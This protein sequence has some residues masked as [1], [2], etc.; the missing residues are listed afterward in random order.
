MALERAGVQL[1]ADGAGPFFAT[2][3]RGDA[4][5]ASFARATTLASGGAQAFARATQQLRLDGLTNQL[6]DQTARLELL[7][8]Q[9][10][11]TAAKYGESSTQAQ[12]KAVAV[13]KLGAQIGITERKIAL[14]TAQMQSESGAAQRTAAS[15]GQIEDGA[16]KAGGAIDQVLIGALRKVGAVGVDMLGKA[17]AMFGRFV[18]DGISG[19]ADY[20][21]NLSLLQSTT[22]A[23]DDQMARA[24]A[25]AKALGADLTLPATSAGSAASAMTAL[26]QAGI[27]MDDAIAGAKGTLQLAAAG[28][29]ADAEAAEYI[30]AALNQF[31]LAGSQAT[32]VADLMAASISAAGSKVGQTGQAIQQA[33]ASFAAAKIPV[34]VLVTAIDLMAKAGIK[35]SDAGTAL[36]TML[37]RLQKPTDEAAALMAHMGI[38]IYDAEGAMRPMRD[39]I[40]QFSTA[41]GGMTQEQRA[42]AVVT[43]FGTDAQRAANIV[44][45]GG[46]AAYDR[47][48]AAVTRQNAA[49]DQAAAQMAG[50]GGAV[51]GLGSQLETL[52]LQALEPLAPL[53]TSAVNATA[54]FVAVLAGRAGPAMHA[55]ADALMA[56]GSGATTVVGA[57]QSGLVP[58]L[59][60]ATAAAL[61][62]AAV[63]SGQIAIVLGLVV[64]RL[65]IA[66]A[67]LMANAA[68][69][70]A[71]VAPYALI[72]V[73]LAGVIAAYTNFDTNIKRAT[74]SL[75]ESRQ[76]WTDSAAALDAYGQS[77]QE[78]Q[79]RLSAHAA[80]IRELRSEI[81]GEIADLARRQ[82][83]GWVTEQ[84]YQ[85]EMAAINAKRAGLIE[86]TAAMQA[87]MDA[88]TRQTAASMTA[89][90]ALQTITAGTQQLGMQARLTADEIAQLG[91]AL[92]Q[93]FDQGAQAVQ[94]YVATEIS[95]LDQANQARRD[96]NAAALAD[97]AARYAQEQAAQA[98]HLGQMLAD[99]TAVQVQLGNISA[100]QAGTILAGI[101]QQFGA[102]QDIAARTFLQMANDID[103]FAASGSG[104][105]SS[106]SAALGGTMDTAV[107]TQQAMEALAKKYEAELVDNFKAGKIDADQLA[108]ALR[109]IPARVYSE[110]VITEKRYTSG[111]GDHVQG[112][113]VSGTRAAGGPVR[114]GRTY[115]VG[116]DGPE[117][118]AFRDDGHVYP[119]DQ[120]RRM[121]ARGLASGGDIG[122]G[123]GATI[124]SANVGQQLSSRASADDLATAIALTARQGARGRRGGR[125]GANGAAATAVPSG[126]AASGSAAAF[127]ML[128]SADA[129]SA[130]ANQSDALLQIARESAAARARIA[131]E[132]AAKLTAIDATYEQQ[133]RQLASNPETLAVL[134]RQYTER[135]AM[136]RAALADDLAA[137]QEAAAQ[138]RQA[139][140]EQQAQRA[141]DQALANARERAEQ[142]RHQGELLID[143][144]DAEAKKRP[145]QAAQIAAMQ[146][147]LRQQYGI[148]EDTLA[149]SLTRG[150]AQLA[151]WLKG[152]GGD[153][154][155]LAAAL[156]G[157]DAQA[158]SAVSDRKDLTAMFTRALEQ[159][160]AGGALT[161]A[162][163]T[164]AL[165]AIPR[166]V[167][168]ALASGYRLPAMGGTGG[169]SQTTMTTNT[170]YQMPIYTNNSP[171]ALQQSYAVL[172]AQ[173]G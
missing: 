15:F 63:N 73:A 58:A 16:R 49:A 32:R 45:A 4:A 53:L 6:K 107:A 113:G 74:Q 104:S 116:E 37:Q 66:T 154:A 87:E 120:T 18:A 19:L 62:Y 17:A 28:M 54:A 7:K 125:R 79:T 64:Q 86:V 89:A 26:A 46:V 135:V 1:V 47:M 126:S 105:A 123:L 144:L 94:S 21:T 52:A 84:Q 106:L 40:G 38:S 149:A 129:A 156:F 20:Q 152:N 50:L 75:L 51:K 76:W 68:A 98:A 30:A 25:T 72:A 109:D 130:L 163:L 132:A 140:R 59:A 36:K 60:V 13:Q 146:Q 114:Q 145:A 164:D 31:G 147:A 122:S 157:A 88:S 67:G 96:G 11:E 102:T 169:V 111:A 10:G 101:E 117:L 83:A 118:V 81:E 71:A 161:G 119:A 92:H 8:R 124:Q 128:L 27:A 35:G 33:G 42:N 55:V 159:Q 43:I 150:Q 103:A 115:L 77:S 22:S 167:D 141:R 160:F 100:A 143:Y 95:F 80:T 69:A 138:K 93:T 9:L 108:A 61:A 91:D 170:T 148:E 173:I 142:R 2:M 112:G 5:M 139:E 155:A 171:A 134:T 99:Y 90:T 39:I 166:M 121:L 85:T 3:E 165:L 158:T 97:S 131:Q 56:I 110:V 168:Q 44:L 57:L 65:A 172:R 24:A 48:F 137:E 136:T 12:A 153:A 41:L 151:D 82:A 23:T 29:I 70:A 133:R 127:G 34:E 14:M 78:T 162:Q